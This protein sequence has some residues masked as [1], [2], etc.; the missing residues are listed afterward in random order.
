M[1][2]SCENETQHK[3]KNF[4]T[5]GQLKR[6]FQIPASEHLNKMADAVVDF[7]ACVDVRFHW[8]KLLML[9]LASLVKTRLYEYPIDE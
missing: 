7:D 8:Q 3:H 9:V 4:A 5:S 2:T 6:S 1:L